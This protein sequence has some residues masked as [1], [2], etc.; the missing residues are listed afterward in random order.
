MRKLWLAALTACSLVACGGGGGNAGST[1]GTG[2]GTVAAPK[3]TVQ[4]VA[5]AN[6]QN[7]ISFAASD[8]T[9]KARASLV[10]AKGVPIANEIVSFAEEGGSLLKFSPDSRKVLTDSK[11]VAEVEITAATA[12]SIGATR[13]TASATVAQATVSG[14]QNLSITSA[15]PGDPQAMAQAINFLDVVPSDKSIV[16]KGS[17]GNGRSETAILRFKVVDASGSPL[18]DVV[19]NFVEPTGGVQVNIATARSNNDGEVTTSVSS[20]TVPTSVVVRAEVDGRSV[21]SQSDLLTVTTGI[22]T[23]AGFDLSASKYSLDTNLSGDPSSIRIAIVDRSGNPVS[24]GVPVVATTDYGRVGTSN[25]GGCQTANGVC[26]VE[27]QVQNPRPA[28]GQFINVAISTVL[29]NGQV[30][31]DTIRLKATSV[32]WL[33]LYQGGSAVGALSTGGLD[34]TCKGT[35]SGT[36][37]TAGNFSA[38]AGTTVAVQSMNSSVAATVLNGSPVLDARAAGRTPLILQFTLQ[39]GTPAGTSQV[40]FTFTSNSTVSTLNLPVTYP[41]CTTATTN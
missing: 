6:P 22:S 12:T 18:K 37:G 30:I 21:T 16:I 31:S 28:D 23:Q 13:V 27:Y 24:D 15:P 8:T 19:V 3:V 25:R 2:G 32:A 5:G 41:A 34:A 17:G 11:G 7:V 9:A 35:W 39:P 40:Q 20:K 26:S 10:D 36:L 38:P 4:V 33:N 1:G 29:G 14:G